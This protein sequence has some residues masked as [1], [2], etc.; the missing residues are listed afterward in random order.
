[1][2]LKH[3][4]CFSG[5]Y[6]S[7]VSAAMSQPMVEDVLKMGFDKSLVEYVIKEKLILTGKTY[8]VYK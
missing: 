5:N 3:R 6:E 1:M 2:S 8:F 7:R 4:S